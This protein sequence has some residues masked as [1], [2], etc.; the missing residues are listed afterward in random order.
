M[1][2]V[3]KSRSCGISA[4]FSKCCFMIETQVLL[5]VSNFFF[6]ESFP[7]RRLHFSMGSRAVFQLGSTPWVGIG[8][9]GEGGG[10][11]SPH[12][13]PLWETLGLIYETNILAL[14]LPMFPLY[15]NHP[16]NSQGQ[17]AKK[18][19]QQASKNDTLPQVFFPALCHCKL[20][21]WFLYVWNT[22]RFFLVGIHSMQG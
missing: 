18:H 22:G 16:S 20:L 7:G 4:I 11:F 5:T 12:T 9:D 19:L 6:Q 2:Q 14:Y 21:G 3:R 1:L 10:G 8:F 15:R 17:N 13:L